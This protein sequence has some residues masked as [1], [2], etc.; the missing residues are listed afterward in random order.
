MVV[1]KFFDYIFAMR[2][3]KRALL[4]EPNADSSCRDR[5]LVRKQLVLRRLLR[6]KTP[7]DAGEY[8]GF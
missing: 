7:R 1:Q 8:Q 3:Q 4:Q 6:G 2:Y 5:V